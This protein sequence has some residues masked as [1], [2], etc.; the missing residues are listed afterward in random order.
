[1]PTKPAHHARQR[2]HVRRPVGIKADHH[3]HRLI[4]R[5]IRL[6][7][8]LHPRLVLRPA[9]LRPPVKHIHL[10]ELV[11]P[12][13]HEIAA[14]DSEASLAQHAAVRAVHLD[15]G[16][17]R[18]KARH[19]PHDVSISGS[20]LSEA[21]PGYERDEV[22]CNEE[23]RPRGEHVLRLVSAQIMAAR[24]WS[25]YRRQL[26]PFGAAQ[27][28]LSELLACTHAGT[29]LCQETQQQRSCWTCHSKHGL[30]F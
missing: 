24:A 30:H 11:R 5:F 9:H 4:E 8:V 23:R 27:V 16:H 3:L 14:Y 10:G 1:M 20:D 29:K 26:R 7:G 15:G 28:G 19:A 13:A 21:L 17:R 18:R 12:Q 22:V 6:C 25:S 2:G